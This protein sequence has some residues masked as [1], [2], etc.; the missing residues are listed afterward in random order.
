MEDVECGKY[1]IVFASTENALVK[2]SFSFMIRKN[3][4]TVSL[5]YAGLHQTGCGG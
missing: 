1:Q 3:S 4:L 5:V 2:P